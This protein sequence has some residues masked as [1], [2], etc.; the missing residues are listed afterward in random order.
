MRFVLAALVKDLRRYRRDPWGLVMWAGVPLL[1]GVLVTAVV[2]GIGSRT[3]PTAH[4]LVAD[5]DQSFISN[6]L[7]GS[8][9]SGPLQEMGRLDQV[10]R[11][12][13]RAKMDAGEATAL[14][15]IPEGFGQA[16]LREEPSR[17]EL[18]TNPSQ[19]ILPQMVE[20]MLD[21]LLD[22]AFYAHRLFGPEI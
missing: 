22:V 4:L 5:E 15:V 12:A 3:K 11:V 20:Q 1:L 2:G 18:L 6:A 14:L 17:L 21:V 16:V 7:L 8:F 19:R 10:D 13:G 9:G